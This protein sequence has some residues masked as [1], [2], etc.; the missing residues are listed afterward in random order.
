MNLAQIDMIIYIKKNI[1][2]IFFDIIYLLFLGIFKIFT[3]NT[4]NK[5]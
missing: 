3:T 4:Y 2:H 1:V 5:H